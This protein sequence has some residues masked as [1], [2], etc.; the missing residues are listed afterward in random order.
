MKDASII[1]EN[2]KE[3]QP[4]TR[5]LNHRNAF[6]PSSGEINFFCFSVYGEFN[7]TLNRKQ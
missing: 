3:K 7:L 5:V 2:Y 4:Q 6:Y 1:L